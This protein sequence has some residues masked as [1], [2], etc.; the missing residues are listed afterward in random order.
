MSRCTSASSSS[1]NVKYD[2]FLSFRGEDTRDNF[3]SHLYDS[4]SRKKIET[5]IDYKLKRGDEISPALLR[6]IEESSLAIIIFSENYAFSSWCLDELVHILHCKQK[7]GL[8]VIPVFY[9]IDPSVVRKQQ[10]SYATA[11]GVLEERFKNDVEKVRRWTDALT[12]AS[13]LSGWDSNVTRPESTL[14]EAIVADILK[15][16][17][18][19]S[20]AGDFKDL[21]GIDN[22]IDQIESLLDFG[23]LDVR[24]IGI[25]GMGGIGKTTLAT[26]VFN[27]FASQFEGHCFLAN[28]REESKKYGLN[29]LRNELFSKLL[30]EDNINMGSIYVRSN[31]YMRRLSQKKVF[32]VL[33]DVD[34][35]EQLEYLAGDRDWF[36]PGSKI[37]I[38]TRDMQVLWNEVDAIY[39]VE[40][41]NCDE[42]I[43]LF[44]L[45]AFKRNSPTTDCTELSE[46]VVKY[47]QGIPLALK[48][49]GSFLRHKR[50]E[51]WEGELS[52]LKEVPNVKIQNVLRIS[53]DGL[54]KV[55]KR[56]FLDIACFFK[57]MARDQVENILNAC[58]FFAKVGIDDLIDKSLIT[59]RQLNEL[60]V[61]DLVQTMG[62]EIVRS[63]EDP[64]KR[65]RLWIAREIYHVLKNNM[66][67]RAI[68]GIFLDTTEFRELHLGPAIFK[69]MHNLRLLKIHHSKCITECSMHLPQGLQSL[70]DALRYLYWYKYPLKSL[71][72]NFLPCNL[73]ELNMP[74]SQLEKLWDGIQHLGNLRH[75]DLS[76]SKNLIEISDLSQA[77]NLESINLDYCTSL[78]QGPSLDFKNIDKL[79][80]S[81]TN[82]CE[83]FCLVERNKPR[84]VGS[85]NLVGC[86]NLRTMKEVSGNLR[87]LNL[88]KTAVEELPP[89]IW[90]LDDLVSLD[91]SDNRFLKSVP[92]DILKLRSLHSLSFNGCS[93]LVKFPLVPR[94]LRWLR[95]SKTTIEQVPSSIDSLPH[96]KVFSLM[97]CKSLKSLPT[98]ICN[99]KSL[100]RLDLFGCSELETFPE[101]LEP[102]EHLEYLDLNETAIKK[103]P[104]SI[105]NLIALSS[106][107]MVRCGSLEFIPNSIYNIKGLGGFSAGNCSKLEK[108]PFVP[109]HSC[110]LNN[111]DLSYCGILEISDSI[112][113]LSSLK[114]LDLRGNVIETIPTSI[115]QL[116]KL[117]LLKVTNCKNLQS[118]PELPLSLDLLYACGCT[119]LEIVKSSRN[120]LVQGYWDDYHVAAYKE[121]LFYGCL[122]LD[123]KVRN[124][125]VTEFQLRVFQTS[126]VSVLK[127]EELSACET[128]TPTVSSCYPGSEIP[129]RFSYQAEGSSITIKLSPHWHHNNFLGFS[130]CTLAS[131]GKCHSNY[132]YVNHL[133]C[134]LHLK[135][136]SGESGVF[137]LNFPYWENEELKQE[138]ENFNS[139]HV[140]MWYQH[141]DFHDYFDAVE[142][143]F[144]F[145]V[146]DDRGQIVNSNNC[147]VK[148]CGIC[149]F[150]LHDA[151][152]FG[153]SSNQNLFEDELEKEKESSENRIARDEGE[154]EINEA[155][156]CDTIEF[157]EVE[158]EDEN[159]ICRGKVSLCF[160]IFVF[161][162]FHPHF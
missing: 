73:V 76:Y 60:W 126:T 61:H 23:S 116:S 148:R 162:K 41:L 102:M 11:F 5:Y 32:I 84:A 81:N 122:K 105:E 104:S 108:F 13:N 71:P 109:N 88:C 113:S 92:T 72:S 145:F 91:I 33:D 94:N 99:L 127:P 70:P 158:E 22:R 46:R 95:L 146:R 51:N 36:G 34:D 37:I 128:S 77:T 161:L 24:I 65:S 157:A 115:K 96:L 131:F 150:Y 149:M 98:S 130:L 140:F 107:T 30:E 69:K 31:F 83:P 123:Q 82:C 49:L 67:T 120:E 160:F 47:A 57:G 153:I 66:G 80:S 6:A 134:E 14:V 17:N 15:K 59:I 74:R 93:S 124:N 142:A 18:V 28:V 7:K 125:I 52:K 132:E 54:D 89:S 90:C 156:L 155:T 40:K 4:L 53:Y 121:F 64:G 9:H 1:V 129:D 133:Y 8:V 110:H 55:E 135:T 114:R 119:S 3:V 16:L 44:H 29:H 26:V 144:E 48:V 45:N 85:L 97:D 100:T 137:C 112:S 2:V 138:K 118:L 38:T 139:D 12:A 19:T 101:I 159:K 35:P 58:G 136:R 106:L 78:L 79:A 25:W 21:V 43:E 103:L 143:S 27:R 56:I 151:E 147:A 62:W 10:G 111:L 68:E 117:K 63:V 39:E 86:S 42:A 50:K 152:Q 154:N 20:P 75:I 87:Y 141:E